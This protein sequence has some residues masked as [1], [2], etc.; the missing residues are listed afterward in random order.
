M[1]EKRNWRIKK[2]QSTPSQR[3]RSMLASNFYT[4]LQKLYSIC[5]R[6]YA[7]ALPA[8]NMRNIK[9]I[10]SGY[11]LCVYLFSLI[12]SFEGVFDRASPKWVESQCKEA[13]VAKAKGSDVKDASSAIERVSR[14][15]S[16]MWEPTKEEVSKW[17]MLFNQCFLCSLVE[18]LTLGTTIMCTCL[19][20]HSESVK[21]MLKDSGS[22]LGTRRS[23]TFSWKLGGVPLFGSYDYCYYYFA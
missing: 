19:I 18:Q 10:G 16:T 6:E 2:T 23:W 11:S 14:P 13:E 20:W 21:V 1:S 7:L 17:S 9:V 3:W 12:A 15:V 5:R 8:L 4:V 22:V